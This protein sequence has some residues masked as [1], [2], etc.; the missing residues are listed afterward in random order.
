MGNIKY[1]TKE[2]FRNLKVNKLMSLA[3]VT[4]LFSCLMLIGIAFMLLVNIEVFISNIEAENVIMVYADVNLETDD[5]EFIKLGNDLEAIPYVGTVEIIEKDSAYREILSELDEGLKRLNA[6]LP[7]DVS[8]IK[9]AGAAGGICGGLYSVYGGKIKSGFDILSEYAGL[10]Q[11]IEQSD[12]II[13]GEGKTDRQT[14]MGKLP[15][16]VSELCKK[17]GKECV[18][19]SGIIEDTQLGT[20]CISLVDDENKGNIFFCCFLYNIFFSSWRYVFNR[21]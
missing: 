10:E 17:H 20:R 11:K 12:L 18:V 14:L 16:R 9:G 3:S 8:R 15:Y 13:T 7:R 2:G 4:V 19:I 21:H 1:L 6:F 5:V